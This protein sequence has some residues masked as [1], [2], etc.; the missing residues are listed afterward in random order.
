MRVLVTYFSYRS[1]TRRL[2][3]HIIAQLGQAHEVT[4]ST[5]EPTTE[6]S[7]WSWLL[8]SFLPGWRAEIRP[9]LTDLT[10]FDVVCIGFPKWSLDC[11]PLNGFL[12]T[13]TVR[14]DQRF[15]L[16]MTYG[17]FDQDRYFRGIAKRVERMGRL[18]G[19][20][21]VK[22][23]RVLA[24][25]LEGEVASFCRRLAEVRDSEVR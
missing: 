10:G 11:P 7:Y 6:R 24:G 9:T 4:V 5:I 13:A 15:A 17:G 12:R 14:T 21:T 2:A 3:Q 18:V 16:F 25:D 23:S 20:L 19:T 22:R 1:A 8:Q